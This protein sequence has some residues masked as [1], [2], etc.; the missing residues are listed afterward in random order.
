[1]LHKVSYRP[2]YYMPTINFGI[3]DFQDKDDPNKKE[4]DRKSSSTSKFRDNSHRS[5]GERCNKTLSGRG[6]SGEKVDFTDEELEAF[7]GKNPKG[8][9]NK[10]KE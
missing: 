10:T 3:D 8:N 1:M 9:A 7:F 5:T 6:G 2:A 4:A